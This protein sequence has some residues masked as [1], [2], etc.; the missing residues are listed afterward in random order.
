MSYLVLA[1]KWRPQTFDDIVSQDWRYG[2]AASFRVALALWA[3]GWAVIACILIRMAG[4][5][6]VHVGWT[7]QVLA[8]DELAAELWIAAVIS[9]TAPLHAL[10]G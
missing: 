9:M 5:I 3:I 7:G 1:R 4:L 8:G 6:V 2:G 10:A